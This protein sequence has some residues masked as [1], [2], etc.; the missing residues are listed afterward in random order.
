M[1]TSSDFKKQH[2]WFIKKSTFSIEVIAWEMYENH[3]IWNVYVYLFQD[4]K[5]FNDVESAKNL[6]F[7]G[8]CTF[9]KFYIK[10]PALGIKYDWQKIDKSLQVGC[11]YSHLDDDYF[12]QCHPDD[13]VPHAIISD[14]DCLI[15]AVEEFNNDIIC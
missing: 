7:H 13:G 1:T 10:E 2:S 8:G 4:N 5:L 11:D 3:W 14:V 15:Q 12:T 6:P 9:D